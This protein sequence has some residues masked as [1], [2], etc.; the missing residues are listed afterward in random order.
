MNYAQIQLGHVL[1][2][3][4]EIKPGCVA[5]LSPTLD[6]FRKAMAARPRIAA[7]L[8][9][10]MRFPLTH[11]EV[12]G[13]GGHNYTKGPLKR[14]VFAESGWRCVT[15][16]FFIASFVSAAGIQLTQGP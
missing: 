15:N 7:Y 3:C 11:N 10:P 2:Q 14:S 6:D 12:R 13:E 5:K 9:S 16:S 4:D 8:A 1:M